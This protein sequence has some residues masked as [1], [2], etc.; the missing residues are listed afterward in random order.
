MFLVISPHNK[1][2][3]TD[4]YCLEFRDIILVIYD[5]SRLKSPGLTPEINFWFRV[6]GGG[7]GKAIQVAEEKWTKDNDWVGKFKLVRGLRLITSPQDLQE[8]QRV[9]DFVFPSLAESGP[10]ALWLPLGA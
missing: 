10:L 5:D 2:N 3:G 7:V 4:F 8:S 1:P 9:G 6:S